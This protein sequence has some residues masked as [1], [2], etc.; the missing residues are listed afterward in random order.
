MGQGHHLL[1]ADFPWL[2]WTSPIVVTD[3]RK[4][5]REMT[6]GL[7]VL[8]VIAWILDEMVR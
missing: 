3:S 4:R 1:Q 2:V 7:Y 8:R 5:F 6:L